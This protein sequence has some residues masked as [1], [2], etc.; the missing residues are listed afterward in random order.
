[1]LH[2]WRQIDEKEYRCAVVIDT[3]YPMKGRLLGAM[4]HGLMGLSSNPTVVE[5][6]VVVQYRDSV[7]MLASSGFHYACLILAA[8]SQ[9]EMKSVVERA[10][11]RNVPRSE[12]VEDMMIGTTEEQYNAVMAKGATEHVFLALAMFDTTKTVKSVAGS[13]PL[14]RG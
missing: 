14:Y 10:R 12:V 1:M 9:E 4:A 3:S 8:R 6:G 5:K 11:K 13:L 2:D 7:D